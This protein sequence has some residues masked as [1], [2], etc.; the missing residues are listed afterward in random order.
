MRRRRPCS[1]RRYRSS[2]C[3]RR[4]ATERSAAI[5]SFLHLDARR[6]L[7]QYTYG[8]KAPFEL[9]AGSDLRWARVGRVWRNAPPASVWSLQRR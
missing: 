7:V 9:P 1:Y 3:R 4:G 2:R 8:L 6:R 5:A